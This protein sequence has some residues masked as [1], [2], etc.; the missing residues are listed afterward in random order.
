[1][2]FFEQNGI[3]KPEITIEQ[4]RHPPEVLYMALQKRIYIVTG[5]FSCG[6]TTTL[7]C[8]QKLFDYTIF[9]EAHLLVLDELGVRADGHPIDHPITP[10]TNSEHFCPMC[11][12][13]EFAQMVLKKQQYTESIAPDGSLIERGFIDPVEYFLRNTGFEAFPDQTLKEKFHPYEKVFLF[14]VIPDVQ[15]AKWGK[16][17]EERIELAYHINDRL[18]RMYKQKGFNVYFI[19]KASVEKRARSVHEIIRE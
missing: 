9:R 17:R 18:Y 16:S 15:V 4:V 12:P 11:N 14:D 8:L 5:A 19:E 6:K 10:I 13:L 2:I 1:M 7:Q 3:I